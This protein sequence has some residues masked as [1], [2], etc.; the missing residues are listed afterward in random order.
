M[1][2]QELKYFLTIA[3]EN[4]LTKAAQRLYVSQSALSQFLGK[5]EKKLGVLLFQRM[6]NNS[7]ML[8][9]AGKRYMEYCEDAIRLWEKTVHDINMLQDGRSQALMIGISSHMQPD[10][11]S[12][13][14]MAEKA[15]NA[16]L[17]MMVMTDQ[18]KIMQKKLLDGELQLVL[19][20]YN[21]EHP[22][23]EYELIFQQ[24]IVL[25]VPEH[26]PLS[27]YSVEKTGGRDCRIS[28]T[29][30][31]DAAFALQESSTIIRQVEEDYLQRI[32][33]H[34]HVAVA[35]NADI[36]LPYVKNGS[37]LALALFSEKPI[38]GVCQVLLD[39]PLYYKS[40]AIHRRNY[41][42]TQEHQGII[43][44]YRKHFLK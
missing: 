21:N 2:N 6:K 16:S 35:A 20:A 12:D 26:H 9:S 42:L 5:L 14:F 13:Y 8:T 34:P 23:L 3:E 40:G 24:E 7:L 36:L 17:Q 1:D 22:E 39:P 10:L 38:A 4:S 18:A 43:Q 32:G 19:G 29:M 41:M 30:A 44:L 33:Y 27:E 11:L 28:L 37:C 31:G 25:A 15:Q